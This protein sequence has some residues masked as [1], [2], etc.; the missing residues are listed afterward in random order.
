V[1]VLGIDPGRTGALALLKNGELEGVV[2]MPDT[3]AALQGVLIDMPVVAFAY[4]E[5]PFL[6]PKMGGKAIAGS[7]QKY[8]ALLASLQWRDIPLREIRPAEWKAKLGLIGKDK[9]ASREM[10]S[11]MFPGHAELFRRVKDD[12]RAE[13]CLIGA[14]G[15]QK[16]GRT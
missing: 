4:V 12:G 2:D 11:Q 5:K 1:I 9:S 7:F 14:Y 6:G 8:G 10:A 15:I 3:T 16:W 13:A